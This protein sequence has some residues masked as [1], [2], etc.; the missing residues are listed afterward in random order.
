MAS[1]KIVKREVGD[2]L[3]SL[4]DN[5]LLEILSYLPLKEVMRQSVLSKRWKHVCSMFP[6]LEFDYDFFYGF[7]GDDYILWER[8]YEFY[9]SRQR[10]RRELLNVVDRMLETLASQSLSVKKFAVNLVLQDPNWANHL[11]RWIERVVL[12]PYSKLEQLTIDL[13]GVSGLV[14]AQGSPT[15]D[16]SRNIFVSKSLVKLRLEFCRLQ[17]WPCFKTNLPSL[18]V[19][20]LERL[21]TDDH[22]VQNL[23]DCCRNLEILTIYDCDG[24]KRLVV[25]DQIHLKELTIA[26]NEGLGFIKI[27]GLSNLSEVE[28]SSPD[29]A[30]ELDIQLDHCENI[31]VLRILRAEIELDWLTGLLAK[32]PLLEKLTLIFCHS[33]KNITISSR[34]LKELTIY[35][36][37]NLERVTLDT[38]NLRE[39]D[40]WGDL[41][42][43]STLSV[44]LIN[45][46]IKRSRDGIQKKNNSFDQYHNAVQPPLP[47]LKKLKYRIYNSDVMLGQALDSLFRI[48]SQPEFISLQNHDKSI[49]YHFLLSYNEFTMEGRNCRCYES[50]SSSSRK[51]CIKDARIEKYNICGGQEIEETEFLTEVPQ[52]EEMLQKFQELQI[53]C[54]RPC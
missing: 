5:L 48:C 30:D 21:Q 3:S 20:I 39:F 10:R 19:L 46:P 41:I 52:D 12:P 31:K 42:E 23:I 44:P 22:A 40:Y 38:P 37:K 28:I 27:D 6:N 49:E 9:K 24:I 34:N 47:Y 45:L 7:G 14:K 35:Q 32:L 51:R 33:L 16:L 54:S 53:C 18:K 2:R 17:H 13:G 36:L 29:S 4:P 26:R 1:N 25:V 8:P 43:L 15:Y 50:S 11:D